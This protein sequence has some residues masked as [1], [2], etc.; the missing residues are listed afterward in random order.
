MNQQYLDTAKPCIQKHSE[1]IN[2]LRRIDAFDIKSLSMHVS[3]SWPTVKT[4]VEDLT[5]NS[6]ISSNGDEKKYLLNPEVGYFLGIAIGA[7]ETKLSVIDFTFKPVDLYKDK[8]FEE[9]INRILLCYPT[10]EKEGCLCFDTKLDYSEIYAFCTQIIGFFL[11]FFTNE[12]IGLNLISIG[13]SF[14]GIIDKNTNEMTFC[15]NIPSLVGLPIDK[16]ISSQIKEQLAFL[17]IPFNVYRD[18]MAATVGEK[19]TLYNFSETKKIYKDKQNVA[20]VYLGYGLS[21]GYIFNN[22]LILGA[23]GAVGEIGHIDVGVDISALADKCQDECY[24]DSDGL[25]ETNIVELDF[26]NGCSCQN[27]FCLEHLIRTFVFN[28]NS[29]INY[30]AKTDIEMLKKIPKVFPHRYEILTELLSK[31]INTIVNMLNVDLIVLSGRILNGIPELRSDL[32]KMMNMFSLKASSKYCNIV[33]GSERLDI[34]AIGAAI[35]SYY[36]FLGGNEENQDL[37]IEWNTNIQ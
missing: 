24:L 4:A 16:I 13:V 3:S 31:A 35:L 28:S 17:K 26:K 10:K 5:Q 33:N 7:T 12:R 30:K 34:V 23:S 20:V 14:P 32:E 37:K 22:R 21:S 15:P 9:L 18:A 8:R 27:K 2:A 36:S 29:P 1:I 6:I 11:D 25:S 19:E